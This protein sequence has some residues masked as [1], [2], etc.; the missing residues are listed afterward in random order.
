[1][2]KSIERKLDVSAT[3]D[4]T[5]NILPFLVNILLIRYQAGQAGTKRLQKIYNVISTES[6]DNFIRIVSFIICSIKTE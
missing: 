3:V 1:M 5:L 6:A 2:E 4:M